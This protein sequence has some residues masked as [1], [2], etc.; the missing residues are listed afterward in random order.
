MNGFAKASPTDAHLE[1]TCRK[2]GPESGKKPLR[3]LILEDV[4]EDAELIQRELRQAQIPFVARCVDTREGYLEGLKGPAPDIIL[5]DFSLPGFTAMEALQLRNSLAQPPP[6]IL[7]TGSQSEEVAVQCMK[8]GADDY[9]LKETLK[10]LP[11]ALLNAIHKN[12]IER[13]RRRAEAEVEKLAAFPRQNPNPIFEVTQFGALTYRNQAAEEMAKAAAKKPDELLPADIGAV[14]EECL[15]TGHSNLRRETTLNGQIFAWSF[16]PIL[17]GKTVHCYASDITER[18]NLEAQ[19]RQSQKMESIGQLAA[20]IAHDFNNVLTIIRGYTSMLLEDNMVEGPAREPVDQIAMATQRAAGLTQQLLTF[21]RK[22]VMRAQPVDLNDVIG[23]VT[24]LLRRIL[25]EDIRL[26]SNYS[27][28]L[29]LIHAD[30]SMVEQI[31]LNL[32][33]NARD[34]M[35]RGGSLTI[36]TNTTEITEEHSRVNSEARP[37]RYV[38]LRVSDT[39]SGIPPEILPR[40]FEPFFTTKGVGKGTGLGLATLYGI[41]KQHHGWVEV[42]TEPAKGTTF[43]IFLPAA[44]EATRDLGVKRDLSDTCGGTETILVVEDEPELRGMVCQILR[45]Y[46]YTTLEAGSGPEAIPIWR[47]HADQV[48]LLLTDMVMPGNMTGRDLAEKLN[49]DAPS[50]K[51]VYTSGYS[52]EMFA[53]DFVFKRGLNFLQ[54]PYHPH[55]LLKVVRDCLDS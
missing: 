49:T 26:H 11:S 17:S 27:P 38:C 37:G 25:G 14:V 6:F 5:S 19:L 1:G 36:G 9:I 4:W 40:I 12:Q 32:A 13:Q 30:S 41:V 44:E 45:S 3:I 15:R 48:D 18:L 28:N 47:S 34:A 8:E 52:V 23:S 51:V 55:A 53:N 31:L 54:K 16:F 2:T 50:L 7:V 46:G 42:L 22:Q 43:R 20:G 10:R 39:G 29:P 33:V 24:K 35:P 21:S